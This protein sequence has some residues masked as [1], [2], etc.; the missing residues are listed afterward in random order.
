[1]PNELVL[2]NYSFDDQFE[3]ILEQFEVAMLALQLQDLQSSEQAFYKAKLVYNKVSLSSIPEENEYLKLVL[4][5]IETASVFLRAM[6]YLSDERFNRS[7][8]ELINCNRLCFEASEIFKKMPP[9]FIEDD[10]YGL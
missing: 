6:F 2:H 8:D 3:D 7:L 9:S 5:S 4:S 1:M 10:A